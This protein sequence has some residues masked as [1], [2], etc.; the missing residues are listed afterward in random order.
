MCL[1]ISKRRATLRCAEEV[2]KE[3]TRWPG[4]SSILSGVGQ[5]F[6]SQLLGYGLVPAQ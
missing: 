3:K 1:E 6:S 4:K 2:G 5:M